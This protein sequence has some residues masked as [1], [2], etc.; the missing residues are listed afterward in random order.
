MSSG[1]V[2]DHTAAEHNQ[3][4]DVKRWNT[5]S[6]INR[7][8]VNSRHNVLTLVG[9][10]SCLGILPACFNPTSRIIGRIVNW[11]KQIQQNPKINIAYESMRIRW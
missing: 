5:V 3:S 8:I 6:H 10:D 7:S 11:Q 9:L 4:A 2:Q 1:H